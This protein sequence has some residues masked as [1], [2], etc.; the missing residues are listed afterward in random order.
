MGTK[1]KRSGDGWAA[2]LIVLLAFLAIGGSTSFRVPPRFDGAGYAVLA[3]SLQSGQGYRSIDHPD[4]PRHVNFPPGYPAVLAGLWSVTGPSA[5][6]A[7]ALS[8]ICVTA[9]VVLAWRW[10]RTFYGRRVAFLLGLA[11]AMNWTWHRVGGSIQSEPLYLLGQQLVLLLTFRARRLGGLWRGLVLGLLLA[12]CVLTRQVGIV[13][14]AV[15][16]LDLGL[17]RRWGVGLASGMALLILLAPWLAW[18]AK[19]GGKT[20]ADWLPGDRLGE[21]VTGNIS[22]YVARL[23]DT[24]TGPFVE[25][26]TVFRPS[27]AGPAMLFA[28]LSTAVLLAGGAFALRSRRRR[29]A[30]LLV[31]GTLA[32]LLVWPF[33]EAGRFLVPLVP[34][35]LVLGV[36][37]LAGIGRRFGLRK[38]R[39]WSA[40]LLLVLAIPYASY[41][42]ISGRSAAQQ[43]LQEPFDA[44]CRWL[45]RH[46]DRPGPVL[47]AYPG[48]VHW[49]TGR[50]GV[51]P[52]PEDGPEEVARL[53]DRY[54][55]AYL[56]V[57][58]NR[59]ARAPDDPI[60]QFVQDRPDL[61]E[62]LY[63][64]DGPVRIYEVQPRV[65]GRP[66]PGSP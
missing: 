4:R 38:A 48:E 27:A 62:P 39:Q 52:Q 15:V 59:F 45:A 42:L 29:L 21:V 30:G 55:V 43:R 10:F 46:D 33:T 66:G 60:F 35:L 28:I 63:G 49:F 8:W 18:Q 56:L 40:G 58:I 25:V 9:A 36:E 22:F 57:T 54:E 51:A 32:L 37:G 64:E 50:Q 61:V 7:H 17:A 3:P 41:A 31:S 65:K 24:L 6:S 13:L 5:A 11:L 14:A 2:V 26:A 44:A 20:Q 1:I 34:A 53:I 47:S 16:L 12:A 19:A 23:P